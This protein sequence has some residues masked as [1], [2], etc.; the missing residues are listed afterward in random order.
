MDCQT[1]RG[2][3]LIESAVMIGL[4]TLIL[5]GG[6]YV[7]LKSHQTSKHYEFHTKDRGQ[8]DQEMAELER[9]FH[10]LRSKNGY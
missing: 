10:Q 2:Q 4:V 1:E 8:Y 5:T 3:I 7:I 6:I 9:I